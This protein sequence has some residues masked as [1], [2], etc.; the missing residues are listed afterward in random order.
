MGSGIVNDISVRRHLNLNAHLD[1]AA[2]DS[3]LNV[4]KEKVRALFCCCG[5]V[6]VLV[7]ILRNDS[8]APEFADAGAVGEFVGAHGVKGFLCEARGDGLGSLNEGQRSG[9]RTKKGF[10]WR[11]LRCAGAAGMDGAKELQELFNSAR[12]KSI[13]GVG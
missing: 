1:G 12:G 9:T 7:A 2:S 13:H 4:V 3:V 8:V 5:W 11:R 10:D 6:Q